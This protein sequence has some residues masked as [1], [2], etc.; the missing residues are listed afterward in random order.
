MAK[1]KRPKIRC[2]EME[3]GEVFK[4]KGGLFKVLRV[5]RDEVDLDNGVSKVLVLRPRKGCENTA[6]INTI[7]P[8]EHGRMVRRHEPK[9]KFH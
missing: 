5:F 4:Y 3:E 8:F 6:P 2:G 1:E 9:P 7:C